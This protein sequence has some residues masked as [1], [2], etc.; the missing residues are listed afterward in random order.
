MT[1]ETIPLVP[2]KEQEF[3]TK[4]VVPI[5]GAHF[6]HDSY[7]AA[8]PVLLPVLMEKLSLS[9]T[10]V[11]TLTAMLQLPAVL[12]PFI[13][14]LADRVSLRYFVILAPGI[15]ATLVGSLG[16]ATG[17]VE[18]AVILF[19]AGISVVCFHAPAPAM[20]GRLAGSQ[21]GKGMSLF[22]AAG[23]L[24]RAVGPLLAVWAISAW[25]LDGYFRVSFIG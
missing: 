18:L 1:T 7:T 19:A 10:L 22:M 8:I 17:Y 2:A 5:V 25:T 20:V 9:L 13:G 24:A 14:Y 3:Q 4:N 6:V 11:G 16:F 12:Y 21:V 23:E 15:T